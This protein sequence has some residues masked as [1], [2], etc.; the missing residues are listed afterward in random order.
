MT[1]E[2]VA[3]VMFGE[4]VKKTSM[5]PFQIMLA[6]SNRYTYEI[7]YDMAW[8]AKQK[9]LEWGLEL[10]MAIILHFDRQLLG[11]KLSFTPCSIHIFLNSNEFH[12]FWMSC[13]FRKKCTKNNPKLTKCP[14]STYTVTSSIQEQSNTLAMLLSRGLDVSLIKRTETLHHGSKDP[15]VSKNM[16]KT[17]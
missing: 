11:N 10:L 4:I 16:C 6:I 5:S 9:A 15:Q 13:A 3:N 8:R 12:K 2:F 7:S 1:A 14:C 17:H